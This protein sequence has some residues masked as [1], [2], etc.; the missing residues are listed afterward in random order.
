MAFKIKTISGV[1]YLSALYTLGLQYNN[2]TDN[3]VNNLALPSSLVEL[4][5]SNNQIVNFNPIQALPTSLNTISIINNQIV[6]FDPLIALP[7]SLL[8]LFLG[9]NQIVTFNP[10]IAL[11]NSLQQ[12]TLDNNQMTTAGYTA[13]ESWANAMSVIPTRGHI[14]ISSNVNSA[15]G[16][17][18]KTIL[19][20]KGWI[21]LA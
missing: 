6:T 18:L 1:D 9:G 2:L 20:S 17:P 4:Y 7:N 15:I 8:Y 11:P 14:W 10:S 16:T 3:V 21:L 5:L 19:E 13:S 12:L